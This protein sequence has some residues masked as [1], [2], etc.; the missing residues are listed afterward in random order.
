MPG[1]VA[2]AISWRQLNPDSVVAREVPAEDLDE[3]KILIEEHHARTGSPLAAGML[4][5]WE[6][7]SR[8]FRQIVPVA[9]VTPEV[10]APEKAEEEAPKTAV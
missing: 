4:A 7:A 6:Q 5:D 9:A 2:Y 8:R 3:L 1:G 10:A